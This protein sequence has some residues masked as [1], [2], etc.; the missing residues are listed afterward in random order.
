[1]RTTW[2]QPRALGTAL[3]PPN[4][5][6]GAETEDL[7]EL[8]RVYAELGRVHAELARVRAEQGRVHAVQGRVHGATYVERTSAARAASVAG[9]ISEA[10]LGLDVAGA[11]VSRPDPS[12]LGVD[13]PQ[14]HVPVGGRP[15]IEVQLLVTRL[16][17]Q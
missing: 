1:M 9:A 13:V 10:L 4:A 7:E 12:H 17:P 11:H 5:Q 14:I 3:L 6:H 15:P 8:G 2:S 16:A